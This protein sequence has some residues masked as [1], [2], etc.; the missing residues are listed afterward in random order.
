MGNGAY[1]VLQ[2]RKGK[3]YVSFDFFISCENF[4]GGGQGKVKP[5][6]KIA[7]HFFGGFLGI[8]HDF[9]ACAVCSAVDFG[10]V[11]VKLF[12]FAVFL[13]QGLV[14]GRKGIVFGLETDDAAFN[15]RHPIFKLSDFFLCKLGL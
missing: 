13:R 5:T 9:S 7:E 15:D 10:N 1:V 11:A 4:L 2:S 14:F 3:I 8:A 12:G 6:V